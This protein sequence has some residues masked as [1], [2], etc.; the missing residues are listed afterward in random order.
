MTKE[1]P[2]VYITVTLLFINTWGSP[3]PRSD[4]VGRRT[5]SGYCGSVV[6]RTAFP[7]TDPKFDTLFGVKVFL[8]SLSV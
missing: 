5:S 6:C 8:L 7:D 3:G 2:K 1:F 4:L